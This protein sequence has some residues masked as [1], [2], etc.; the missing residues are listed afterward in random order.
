MK[1]SWRKFSAFA[2]VFLIFLTVASAKKKKSKSSDTEEPSYTADELQATS[3]IVP[4]RRDVSYFYG[5]EPEII[6]NVEKGTPDSLRAAIT[7]LKRGKDSMAENEQ[8]L[9]YIAVSIMQLC[10]KSQNF[11]EPTTGQDIKND[12]TGAISSSRN[13]FYD[14]PS[15]PK[16]FFSCALPSLVLAASETR[17]DYY[18]HSE[19]S[20]LHALSLNPSSVFVNYLLG[21]LY[22]RMGDFKRSNEYFGFASDMAGSCFECSYAFA[23]SFMPL[24]DPSSAFSL[25]E[26]MLVSYPQNKKLLQLCAESS[27]AAGDYVN[28]ELY[29]GRV[30]QIE[31]ENSYYLLFRARILVQKGEYIRAASLLDA[32]SRKDSSS[33]DY[34]VLRFAVQ[35]NWNKNISA[36]TATIENALVL[37]PDD[38]QIILE[39]ARLA[40]DSGVKIA[41]KSGE[42]LADQILENDPENFAALQIKIDSM[43]Y[44]RKWK[45]A[46]KASSALL[47]KENVPNSA[48]FTHI[49]ICLSAGHKDEAWQYASKLYS[50]NSADEEIVQSYIDVLV[51]TGRS[52]EASRLIAQLLPASAAKMKSFLYYQ[53]S[54]L[55]SGEAAILADLRSSLTANPRNRDSLFRLYRIYYN[56]KEYRKAQYYLKQVVAL[57]P[58]DENLLILNQELDRLLKK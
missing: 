30:L 18:D 5:I 3:I 46:Y 36:A 55:S 27:F 44:E 4:E 33:R 19:K 32:Y 15:E 13:G 7:L 57:S 25:S 12:Y 49:K 38:P 34:L 10:W 50:E 54:F 6:Q 41:G 53:R 28:S 20:L 16:D 42:A 17:N 31:P 48:F 1:Q 37:Y 26:K 2:C 8:V 24:S 22:K 58:K 45:E 23:E 11:T 21:I 52:A 47:Q 35:K 39:A 51:S 14:S 9:H 43:V 40:S 56:K 29:V